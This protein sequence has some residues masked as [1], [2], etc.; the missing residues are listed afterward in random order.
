M[1][2][3]LKRDK[4]DTWYDKKFSVYC[5][6]CGKRIISAP[7]YRLELLGYTNPNG[8]YCCKR[9]NILGKLKNAE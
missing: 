6:Y 8:S 1:D 9:C 7:Y 2:E 5:R 3:K 4:P